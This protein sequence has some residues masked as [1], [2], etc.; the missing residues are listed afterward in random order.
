MTSVLSSTRLVCAAFLLLLLLLP[1]LL[2]LGCESGVSTYPHDLLYPVRS[3]VLVV[4]KA[5]GDGVN[6]PIPPGKLDEFVRDT[7]KRGGKT[8]DPTT[9]AAEVRKNLQEEMR[10]FFGRPAEPWVRV[11]DDHEKVASVEKMVANLNLKGQ[12]LRMGSSLYRQ[13]CLHCHGV[14]GDGRGPTGPWISPPPRDYRQGIFK[15]T[16]TGGA[17]KPNRLDLYRTLYNGLEGSAMPPFSLLREDELDALVSYVIHLSIRGEVEFTALQTLI[18][19]GDFENETPAVFIET[20]LIEIL[21]QWDACNAIMVT[22]TEPPSYKN[23]EERL[24]AVQR[25]YRLFTDENRN[26][27]CRTCHVDFGRQAIYR[28]DDWGTLGKPNNLT[29]GIYRGGRKPIDTY[30]R[31]RSGIKPIMQKFGDKPE[32]LPEQQAW[33]LIAFLQALPYP[34]MLPSEVR[35]IVYGPAPDKTEAKEKK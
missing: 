31:I 25:G 6:Q 11:R 22:P 13:H 32:E 23:E 2:G 35:K 33:D 24:D 28:F 9:L 7:D 15:F 16:S 17:P 30:W 29:A 19:N 10:A 21:E 18:Q 5:Q 20:K 3:D 4:Q 14:P 8:L 12:T 34:A 26:L 1:L 27:A